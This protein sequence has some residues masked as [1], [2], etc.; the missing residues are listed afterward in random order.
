MNYLQI[1]NDLCKVFKAAEED[2]KLHEQL[3]DILDDIWYQKLTEAEKF[4]F[5][6]SHL[7]KSEV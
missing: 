4:G 2:E 6:A 5:R 3:G 7:G 1:Y